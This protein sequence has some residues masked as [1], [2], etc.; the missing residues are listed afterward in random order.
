MTPLDN[1]LPSTLAPIVLFTFD[2]PNHTY[3]TLEALKRN[4]LS[5]KSDLIIYSDGSRNGRDAERVRQVRN[6]VNATSGFRNIK[7]IERNTNYGLAR[8][9]I[10][11]ICEVCTL[12]DRIIVLEDDIITNTYFLRFMNEALDRYANEPRV[13]HIS[14]WNAP[15]DP[16]DLRDTFFWRVMDCWGWATWANRWQY[17]SRNTKYLLSQWDQDKI[18]RFNL[19]GTENFW[20]QVIGNHKG[21]LNTWAIFWYATIFERNGLCLNPV[22]S[23]VQNIGHDGSG[24]NCNLNHFYETELDAQFPV[25]WPCILIENPIAVKRIQQFFCRKKQSPLHHILNRLKFLILPKNSER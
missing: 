13:W 22:R 2:R 25:Q 1:Y 20:S 14:G 5:N 12:Y 9:I 23:Y 24:Q 19:C 10:E 4:E 18:Y 3:H 17:F 11:G 8:N 7:V 15:I 16:H 21:K 6:I